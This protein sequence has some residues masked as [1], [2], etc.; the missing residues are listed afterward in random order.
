MSGLSVKAF[1]SHSSADKPFVLAVA[2]QLGRRRARFD[3]WEFEP[4]QRFMEAIRKS[5]AASDLFVLFA[6]QSSLKSLWVK[7]EVN[8]AEELLRAEILKSA[9][10]LIIDQQTRH[11]DLPA[12][13]QRALVESAISPSAA[14]RAVV[15]GLNRL[16]GLEH[17]ALFIGREDLLKEV[18]EKL[19]PEPESAPPHVLIA[20]G[21]QGIGRRTF[22]TRAA[23]D[24][25]SVRPG[26][27]FHLRATDGLDALHMALMDELGWADT[28]AQVAEAI[29]QFQ[30]ANRQEK[31][32][33]LAQMIASSALGN[34]FPTIV[35]DGA[36]IDSSGRYTSDASG[37][38]E[39]LKAYPSAIIGL[40]HT[41]RPNADAREF[42]SYGAVFTRVP[43]LSLA[44]TKLLLTQSFRRAGIDATSEQLSELAPYLE[45]YPPAVQLAAS[46]AREYGLAAVIADK[47][48]LVDFQIRTFAGIME[49]L[50]LSNDEWAILR[51]L[52][53]ETLLPL[54]ALATVLH[55]SEEELARCL[56]KL[57]DLN[58]VLAIG[59]NYQIAFPVRFAV[60]SLKGLLSDSEYGKLAAT[61]KA[62]YWDGQDQF[63]TFEII[64]ATVH[65]AL[66]SDATELKEFRSIMIPSM[67]YRSAKEHYDRGGHDAWGVAKRFAKEILTADSSH[68]PALVL[69]FKC[70][71][72]LREWGDAEA[73]LKLIRQRKLPDQHFLT[74]FMHSKQGEY[75]KAVTSFRLALSLGQGAVEVF[76]GLGTCLFRLEELKQ[77]EDVIQA[78]LKQRRANSLL[79]DLAAQIAIAKG[80][81]TA[82]EQYI[83]QLSR[84]RADTD[85]N[86]RQATL[87]N[88]KKQFHAALPY[89]RAAAVGA[90]G[91]RRRFEV[92]A[93]L[94]DTLIEVNDFGSATTELDS[95]DRRDRFGAE[96]KDI[97]MGLRCKL[98]L[99]QGKWHDADAA[100]SQIEEKQRGVHQALRQEILQQLVAD[101]SV[102][103]GQRADAKRELEAIQ[104]AGTDQVSLFATGGDLEVDPDTGGAG[105]L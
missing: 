69:L 77:A 90:R 82:A 41:R 78:G 66:R 24:F 1:L 4:G 88:A 44:A 23:K 58:L 64:Q 8:E 60:N 51:I 61:L 89:A 63:P 101:L 68:V 59:L 54:T 91:F 3:A 32:E 103:P 76:H 6:S 52:S 42:S 80:N 12:W 57:V 16:R 40:S 21:L 35:D 45:G 102:T 38:L 33:S 27:V 65:A 93:T 74:G 86:H 48:I 29:R 22:I 56:R 81:F 2:N 62:A 37:L 9:L 85:F 79:L 99:R 14:S 67:L 18:S 71:V 25:L 87:L 73:V 46:L 83:D 39:A 84:V 70:H 10:V 105:H 13:M 96:Y 30:A 28:K 7:F 15:H 50:N 94:V 5:V 20:S 34:V 17:E 47:S 26:P 53:S 36:L 98:Y 49:K 11:S 92:E 100:W 104:N 19:I 55:K 31:L 95:L 97:R 72:R 75:G 43:P